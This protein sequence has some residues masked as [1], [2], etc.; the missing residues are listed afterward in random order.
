MDIETPE[1]FGER[2]HH[3]WFVD[4]A[5]VSLKCFIAQETDARD[6]AIRNKCVERAIECLKNNYQD[7]P[8][9]ITGMH[10]LRAAIMAEPEAEP[11]FC[12]KP[13]TFEMPDCPISEMTTDICHAFY[14]GKCYNA[15]QCRPTKD[16][17]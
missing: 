12:D 8:N 3:E 6:A 5:G 15:F 17:V 11:G 1:E 16:E 13:L 2:V 7:W 9:I 10:Q 4:T 14:C